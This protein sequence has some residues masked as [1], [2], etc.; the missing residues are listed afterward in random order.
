MRHFLYAV[1]QAMVASEIYYAYMH[2]PQ[3]KKLNPR[4]ASNEQTELVQAA[5]R[6]TITRAHAGARFSLPLYYS[7]G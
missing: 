5:P 7:Y 1:T 3:H 2:N 4:H 6:P